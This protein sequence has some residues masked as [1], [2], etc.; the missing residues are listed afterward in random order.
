MFS[1]YIFW[2]NNK[3]RWF[4]QVFEKDVKLN[5]QLYIDI[6]AKVP[7]LTKEDQELNFAL[8]FLSSAFENENKWFI[9]TIIR[10]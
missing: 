2:N 3:F 7:K 5:Q 10:E 4:N 8:N 6:K 1:C 9:Q